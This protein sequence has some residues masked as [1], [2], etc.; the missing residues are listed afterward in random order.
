MNEEESKTSEHTSEEIKKEVV[1]ENWK[2]KYLLTLAEMENMRKRMQKERYEVS[3]F[4]IEGVI[5]E[6]L[7][8]MDNIK[9]AL[10]F[11]SQSSSEV[12]NWAI[13]FEMI[14]PCYDLTLNEIETM[15]DSLLKETA[16]S[17]ASQLALRSDTIT[18]TI[19]KLENWITK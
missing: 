1:E 15:E 11:A 17:Q 5:S 16:R 9:N 4:G 14:H 7:P 19:K 12:K 18:T 3:K 10:K 13:E 6:F 2:E 8:T